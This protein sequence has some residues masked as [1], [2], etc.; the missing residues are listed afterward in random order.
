MARLRSLSNEEAAACEAQI[1]IETRRAGVR[2]ERR[3]MQRCV[4]L[5]LASLESEASAL[6]ADRIAGNR[7]K[8]NRHV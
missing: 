3:A 4:M 7:L 2:L 8:S 5:E 1:A 6:H